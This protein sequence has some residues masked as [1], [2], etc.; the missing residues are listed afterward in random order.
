MALNAIQIMKHRSKTLS[1]FN[2]DNMMIPHWTHYLSPMDVEALRQIATSKRLSGNLSEKINRIKMIMG[3]RGFVRLAGGTNRIVF[4]YLED[5]R[6]VAKVAIDS[7]GMGDNPA[8]FDNQWMIRPYCTRM[9]WVTDCGTVGFA[10]RVV[11]ITSKQEFKTMAE[12]IFEILYN[13][14]LGRYIIEDV[15]TDF[16]MNWGIRANESPVLLDYPYIYELDGA[17]LYCRNVL[18]DGTFCGG[19]IDY[20]SGLNF[21]ACKRCGRKYLARE[22]KKDIINNRI[23]IKKGGQIPMNIKIKAGNEVIGQSN[24]C[25]FIVRPNK[26]R[27]NIDNHLS[28]NGLKVSMNIKGM[29]VTK[30]TP[31]EV[32]D[33]LVS[34]SKKPAMMDIRDVM[35]Q[36]KKNT[37]AERQKEEVKQEY[38][39]VESPTVEESVEEPIEES[40]VISEDD[41]NESEVVEQRDEADIHRTTSTSERDPKGRIVSGSRHRIS[42]QSMFIPDEGDY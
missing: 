20:D 23:I 4:R 39:T 27:Q 37:E 26:Q 36:I 29:K 12:D 9:Y 40:S 6:F 11:P 7:V 3:N 38:E 18:P 17:G 15:G 10:E 19:E 1:E 28:D 16:F 14:I 24:S 33:S 25:E 2:F 32:V 8:E 31:K 5:T 35:A 30:D 42:T 34:D 21:T 13:K 22:L 41:S